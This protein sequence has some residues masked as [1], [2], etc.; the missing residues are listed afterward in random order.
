MSK[1]NK[2]DKTLVE[3]ILDRKKIAYEQVTFET[4]RHGN[5]AEMD[6]TSLT[7]DERLVYKTLVASGNKTGPIVAVVPLDHHLSL[8]KFAAVSGN[9]KVE[10]LPLKI[11]EQ[12]TG[13]VHGA[14]TPVGIHEQKHFPI[15]IEQTAKDQPFM[16]VSAGKIGRSVKLNPLDLQQVTAATF[17]DLKE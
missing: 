3:K 16:V 1:K 15:Y 9:K 8:K 4:Q 5:V 17:A 14:N 7:E 13:Y 11:L 10:M 6:T 2:I 12:T